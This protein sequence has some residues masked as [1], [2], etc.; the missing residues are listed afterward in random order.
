M[1]EHKEG[2]SAMVLHTI[3]K[4]L[5]V[6][7]KFKLRSWGMGGSQLWKEWEE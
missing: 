2:I 1:I 3:K 5:S 4:R 6:E 7:T